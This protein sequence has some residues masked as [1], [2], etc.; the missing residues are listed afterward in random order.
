MEYEYQLVAGLRQT[1]T[2][3]QIQ[4]LSMLALTTQELSAFL[5][6]EFMENPLIEREESSEYQISDDFYQ[7]YQGSG[8]S[9]SQP[10]SPEEHFDPLRNLAVGPEVSVS[11]MLLEQLDSRVYSEE[12]WKI[13]QF[14]IENLD[15]SGFFT[16]PLPQLAEELDR[17]TPLLERLLGDLK[18][19]EPCGVFSRDL[20]EC[21]VRQL[22]QKG[23]QDPKLIAL[24][25]EGLEDLLHQHFSRLMKKLHITSAKMDQYLKIITSLN[26]KPLAPWSAAQTQYII[27]DIL[28]RLD[29]YGQ[30]EITL[31]DHW[32][33]N[34]RLNDY[35]CK[36][37][38]ETTDPQ[39]K[40]YFREKFQRAKN[41]FSNIEQRQNT[42]LSLT[43][44]VL[45]MQDAFFRGTGPLVPMSMAQIS[46]RMHV[47]PSTISRAVKGKYLQFPGGT[48]LMRTLFTANI[49]QEDESGFMANSDRI[50]SELRTLVAQENK[51]HP[52]SDMDLLE[53]L[54]R[55]GFK[56]SRRT[57]AKYRE[58]C[59]IPSSYNRKIR[60]F[61]GK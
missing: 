35:Y 47:N 26:P 38:L 12:E 17:P 18:S 51:G 32:L 41:I 42:L 21:L 31:N 54:S 34:Y 29:E 14:L 49:C 7:W 52:L 46:E 8:R 45:E 24:V 4:F 60:Q 23:M 6:R 1:L 57:V 39:L 53:L 16:L 33:G 55:S 58:E 25:S 30:W 11:Q 22:Q 19:L 36:L 40:Q 43:T 61:P 56:I 13:L 3:A 37:M 44:L 50:K 27:P 59:G 2:Q 20:S 28:C 9:F 15:D 10:G 5:D 48:I